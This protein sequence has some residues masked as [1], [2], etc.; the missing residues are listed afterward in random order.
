MLTYIYCFMIRQYL[1]LNT[2]SEGVR[3]INGI[4]ALV[5]Q[6]Q[7]LVY[8]GRVDHRR[9]SAVTGNR[10]QVIDRQGEP[11]IADVSRLH[12]HRPA[13]RRSEERRVGK[14]VDLGGRRIIKK[15]NI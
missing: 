14:S 10:S 1:E 9:Q 8:H 11:Q 7:R 2:K 15:K 5:V 4:A 3:T 6:T 12:G 13:Q